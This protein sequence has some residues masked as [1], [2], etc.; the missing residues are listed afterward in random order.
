MLLFKQKFNKNAFISF[1]N[2]V[3]KPNS[4]ILML[5]SISAVF[6]VT[7]YQIYSINIVQKLYF[8]VLRKDQKVALILTIN[9]L[10]SEII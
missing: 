10:L 9:L 7:V 6:V 8:I 2:T 4:L 3:K 1:I 5:I